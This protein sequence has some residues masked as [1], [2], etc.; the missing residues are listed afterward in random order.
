MLQNRRLFIASSMAAAVAL[1]ARANDLVI[2]GPAPDF[3]AR[4]FDGR[5]VSLA[6]Y[7][8]EVLII[9]FWAT[10]CAPC[11]KEMPLLDT[12][13]R[14]ADSRGYGLKILAITTEDSLPLET[15]RPIAKQVSFDMARYFHGP[16]RT[17]KAVPTNYIIDR[18]GVLRYAKAAAFDLDSLNDVLVPLLQQ[19]KPDTAPAGPTKA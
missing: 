17:L 15:L 8:G 7:R 6:D 3:G 2:N 16:Y 14:A 18:N 19:P 12:Y 13:Y 4:T 9:N 5:D 1:P 10:W 11:K